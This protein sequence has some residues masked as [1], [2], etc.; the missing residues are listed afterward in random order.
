VKLAA[1]K[2]EASRKGKSLFQIN[3]KSGYFLHDKMIA[4]V[5]LTGR[6]LL[7][8]G[9]ANFGVGSWDSDSCHQQAANFQAVAAV[10]SSR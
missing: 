6:G 10:G 2:G 9:R 3:Q 1:L 4:P 7:P 5:L 8:P